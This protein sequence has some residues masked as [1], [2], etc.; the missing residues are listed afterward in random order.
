M[1]NSIFFL[2]SASTFLASASIS[3]DFLRSASVKSEMLRLCGVR[4]FLGS[5]P[6]SK[7]ARSL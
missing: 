5:N 7:M 6:G 1:K 4:Q 2:R 3:A